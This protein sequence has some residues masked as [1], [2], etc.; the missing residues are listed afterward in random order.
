M[1][2]VNQRKRLRRRRK[3]NSIGRNSMITTILTAVVGTVINDLSSEKSVIK[4]IFRSKKTPEINQP[5]EQKQILNADFS[6]LEFRSEKPKEI[7]V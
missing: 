3:S 7:E 6:V 2:S 1:N 5:D 4:Q